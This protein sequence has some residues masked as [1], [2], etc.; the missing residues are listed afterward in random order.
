MGEFVVRLKGKQEQIMDDLIKEGYFNTK[1][2][3]IRAG[4]LELYHKYFD[5][6]TREEVELINKAREYE[7]K[8]IRSGKAKTYTLDEIK[9]KL[10]L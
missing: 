8:D 2:E 4:L 3:A 9:Q 6:V 5:G 1:S 10:G 7:M